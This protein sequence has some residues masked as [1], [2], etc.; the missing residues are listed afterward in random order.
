[1]Y[2]CMFF[3]VPFLCFA[4]HCFDLA[5]LCD[6]QGYQGLCD[7]LALSFFLSLFL[8]LSFLFM[9]FCSCCFS[10]HGSPLFIFCLFFFFS[11][12]PPLSLSVSFVMVLFCFLFRLDGFS[13]PRMCDF[14]TWQHTLNYFLCS[15][16]TLFFCFFVC[17]RSLVF[18]SL[19]LILVCLSRSSVT[20]NFYFWCFFLLLSLSFLRLFFVLLSS[21]ML[22]VSFLWILV[23]FSTRCYSGKFC[24]S[25]TCMKKIFSLKFICFAC[26]FFA[27]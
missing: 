18:L 20:L 23:F 21:F 24:L 17:F 26:F 4:C 1:M 15:L 9:F 16:L 7:V 10:W 12:H 14:I 25:L 13:F 8:S 2:V 5:R 19:F 3:L 6:F 11:V 22:T 27:S